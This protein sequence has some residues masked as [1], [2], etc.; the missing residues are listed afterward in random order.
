MSH[1]ESKTKEEL[2][3][4]ISHLTETIDRL[5]PPPQGDSNAL[6]RAQDLNKKILQNL[7]DMIT[8]LDYNGNVVELVSSTETNHLESTEMTDI[9]H[10]NIK[11]F[12]PEKAYEQVF[13]NM[14]QVI[15][16]QQRGTTEH[17]LLSNGE[18]RHYENYITPL[19]ES[20]LLCV[21]RDISQQYEAEK[22]NKEQSD[23]IIQLNFLMDA[24]INN[25]PVY[26][27]IKDP[28]HDFRYL[29]L[30][31]SFATRMGV[32]TQEAVGKNDFE[33]FPKKE[34]M[35]NFHESDLKA[36]IHGEVEYLDTQLTPTGESQFIHTLKK[37]IDS[38]SKHSY[39]IGISW[40]ITELK[41]NE[42]RLLD[43]LAKAEEA[44]KLKSAFLANMSH[45][46]RTPLNAIVGF[47]KVI[48]DAT[49]NEDCKLY[50]QIIEKNSDI[51]LKLFNDILDLSALKSGMLSLESQRIPLI[52]LCLQLQQCYTFRL[53]DQVKLLFDTP[54]EGI[55]AKA[56]WNRLTQVFGNLLNNAIKFTPTG[57]IHFGFNSKKEYI[58]CY[59]KDTGIGI[60]AS[61]AATIFERFGKVDDFTQG[62]GL[63]LNLCRS[64][65]EKMGGRIW[66]H[67]RLHEGTTF[68]FTLP[69][70]E[71]V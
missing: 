45:E 37:R 32:P 53:N 33:L 51:L 23:E 59:V 26:L 67:S 65:I 17:E 16:T 10:A 34:K 38:D 12:L 42:Q 50:A 46:I 48:A 2:I 19:D 64:L 41:R 60:P 70:D 40:D 1:Y 20:H 49:D 30:N 52:D 15:A 31:K 28:Q 47:S 3:A 21:C 44:D 18:T 29:Y 57:E 66:V 13:R 6:H 7:P 43:A 24:I 8:L 58:E 27:F 5:S 71:A 25:V 55:Y 35:S 69:K 36:L 63:G 56:D 22:L 4:I 62:S 54:R 39:I 68:F 61:K 14:Q 11:T 9:L